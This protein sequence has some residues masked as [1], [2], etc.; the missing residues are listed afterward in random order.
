[1]SKQS[2]SLVCATPKI[3]LVSTSGMNSDQ[4]GRLS[5]VSPTYSPKVCSYFT[6][7]ILARHVS[8]VGPKMSG[9]HYTFPYNT[10]S[11]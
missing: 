4:F 1:M 6:F 3:S 5:G 10:R 8:A 7:Y 2:A 11:H 9:G